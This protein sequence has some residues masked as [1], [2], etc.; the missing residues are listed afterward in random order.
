MEYF[1]YA[2]LDPTKDEIRLLRI[3]PRDH[4]NEVACTLEKI[5]LKEHP[6]YLALSYAWGD[7][8]LS[9]Q[10]VI[11][12]MKVFITKNL[13]IALRHLQEHV[14]PVAIWIDA[15]CI[16]QNDVIEKAEQVT[17]MKEIYQQA[18]NVLVWL[19]PA[20]D[21]S[22]EV[23][24]YLEWIGETVEDLGLAGIT[25]H[26][27][28][29]AFNLPNDPHCKSVKDKLEQLYT[30]FDFLFPDLFP[31]QAHQNFMKRDWCTRSWVVQELA[32]ARGATFM[33]GKRKISY[34]HLANA[35]DFFHRYACSS[36]ERSKFIENPLDQERRRTYNTIMKTNGHSPMSAMLSFRQFYQGTSLRKGIVEN[37]PN[38]SLLSLLQKTLI[39]ESEDVR[40]RAT[41]GRDKIYALMGLA[42][43]K[44]QLGI[45]INYS[46][47]Y[48]STDLY[49]D[50][51]RALLQ[52]GGSSILAFRPRRQIDL[53]NDLPS[54]VCDWSSKIQLP[55]SRGVTDKPFSASGSSTFEISFPGCGKVLEVDG[56]Q[57]G[58]VTQRI[59][60]SISREALMGGDCSELPN[61]LYQVQKICHDLPEEDLARL[62]IGDRSVFDTDG[63]KADFL[64]KARRATV[65]SALKGFRGL[66]R[67]AEYVTRVYAIQKSVEWDDETEKLYERVEEDRV[68][69]QRGFAEV[70]AYGGSLLLS[71]ERCVF[72]SSEGY[73]GLGPVDLQVGDMICILLGVNVPFIVRPVDVPDGGEGTYRIVGEA[74]V[75]NIMD[76]EFMEKDAEVVTFGLC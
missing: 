57:V 12:S 19:G 18:E 45:S 15:L 62:L 33:C 59:I 30:E 22:D 66:K 13:E 44:E 51:S 53:S 38:R 60:P 25:D 58:K 28:R 32:V 39:Y 72:R 3:L 46:Q 26:D 31:W 69:V 5:S 17:K 47:D 35:D 70:T 56:V 14:E 29:E 6:K 49:K 23:I 67:M 43:D 75:H 41:D 16:N 42:A 21:G 68:E 61:F 40:L 20:A 37:R 9:S 73:V 36:R 2:P 10:I 76:G 4:E 54:W 65:A 64:P 1:S 7:P 71:L 24:G 52:H 50:V 74:Y 55:F 63:M 8:T 11:N 48:T 34:D 27:I